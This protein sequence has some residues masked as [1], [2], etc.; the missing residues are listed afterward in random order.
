MQ[1]IEEESFDHL[2]SYGTIKLLPISKSTYPEVK[3]RPQHVADILACVFIAKNKLKLKD[4]GKLSSEGI[5][6]HTDEVLRL[7]WG[8]LSGQ[9]MA[10]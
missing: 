5:S 9:A 3:L 8:G 6:D 4:A 7:V 2:I 1:K 10:L